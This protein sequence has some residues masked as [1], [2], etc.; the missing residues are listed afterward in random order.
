MFSEE[1]EDSI[2]VSHMVDK[3]FNKNCYSQ[4]V[5]D[6]T[7]LGEYVTD[8]EVQKFRQLTEDFY[9]WQKMIE[10]VLYFNMAV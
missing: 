5:V 9:K 1:I 7:V 4:N 6:V 2:F 10:K 8:A 3:I